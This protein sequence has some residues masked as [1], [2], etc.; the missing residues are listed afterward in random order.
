MATVT[1]TF[2]SDLAGDNSAA[3]LTWTPLTTA[4][5][6]GSPVDFVQYSERCVQVVGTFGA[7]GTLVLQGSNDGTNWF[8]L[9]NAQ[10]AALSFTAAG[11]KQVVE[12]PRYMCPLITGGDG[13]T[14]L[15]MTL[16]MRRRNPMRT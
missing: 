7:A 12:N 9:N 8:T 6:D 4:N 2:S 1:P 10:G 3:M 11:L 5:A 14:S 13:T 16:V 15:T